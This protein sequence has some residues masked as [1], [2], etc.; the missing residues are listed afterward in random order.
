MCALMK[1]LIFARGTS[2]ETDLVRPSSENFERS[3]SYMT[4]VKARSSTGSS[5]LGMV[6]ML[7]I[8]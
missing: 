7:L 3:S 1:P 8:W 2:I 5:A 4:L 6:K